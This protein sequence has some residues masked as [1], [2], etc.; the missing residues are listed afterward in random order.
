P[1]C[2]SPAIR[3]RLLSQVRTAGSRKTWYSCCRKFMGNLQVSLGLVCPGHRWMNSLAVHPC[4]NV[5]PELGR[6]DS[7]LNELPGLPADL[8]VFHGVIQA[9]IYQVDQ[10]G[11]LVVEQQIMYAWLGAQ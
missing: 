2:R 7:V 9:A 5:L 6:F 4:L 1:P 3:P 10:V 8:L 11:Q